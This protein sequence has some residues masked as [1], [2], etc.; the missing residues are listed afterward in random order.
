M[1]REPL[2]AAMGAGLAPFMGHLSALDLSSREALTRQD[3]AA[4][5][6]LA[7]MFVAAIG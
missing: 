3:P 6:E 2:A 5:D 1:A 4:L 7:G